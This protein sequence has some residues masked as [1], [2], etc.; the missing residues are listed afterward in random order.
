MYSITLSLTSV[1][2]GVGVQRHAVDALPPG[3][4]QYPLYWRLD[5]PQG[6][7]GRVQKFST[8][9]ECDP[10]TVQPVGSRCTD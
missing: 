3:K 5:G 4:A 6:R 7:T 9:P 8:P 10:R 1:L 2:E